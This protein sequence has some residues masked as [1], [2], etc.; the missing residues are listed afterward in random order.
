MFNLQKFK[1]CNI[2]DFSEGLFVTCGYDY[3]SF[4]YNDRTYMFFGIMAQYVFPLTIATFFYTQIV[5]AVFASVER[6]NM[7]LLLAF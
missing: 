1:T 6:E 2:F 7:A 5:S 4:N 3:L